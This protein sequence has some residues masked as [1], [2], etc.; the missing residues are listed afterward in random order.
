MLFRSVNALADLVASA[1]LGHP[2]ELSPAHIRRRTSPTEAETL[3][4]AY[5][6]LAEGELTAG[7]RRPGWAADWERARAENFAP[8][9]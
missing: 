6:W 5:E 7:T 1:G 9:S 3:L 2:E 8:N 4:T